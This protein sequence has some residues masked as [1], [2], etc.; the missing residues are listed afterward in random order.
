MP[1]RRPGALRARRF[2]PPPVGLLSWPTRIDRLSPRSAS[3]VHRAEC[4]HTDSPGPG[5][6]LLDPDPDAAHRRTAPYTDR[7]VSPGITGA[8]LASLR[9]FLDTPGRYLYLRRA[10]C[11]CT[12]CELESNPAVARE[13]LDG[14][15]PLLP[16]YARRDLA[17]L[18]TELDRE[19]LHRTLPDAFAHREPWRR[20]FW[21][22][23]RL[24]DTDDLL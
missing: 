24:Y 16:R 23:T 18:L 6:A 12:R 11:P 13:V 14:M 10:Y 22:Y 21:W 20:G 9:R 19:L 7:L 5:P 2:R 4:L 17:S 15:L 1:R 8:A 3:A